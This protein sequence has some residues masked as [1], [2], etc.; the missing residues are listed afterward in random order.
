ML[1]KRWCHCLAAPHCSGHVVPVCKATSPFQATHSTLDHSL[2]CWSLTGDGERPRSPSPRASMVLSFWLCRKMTASNLVARGCRQYDVT[3]RLA[4]ETRW[5]SEELEAEV[6]CAE[7]F[8]AAGVLPHKYRCD[9]RF[10]TRSPLTW[11]C[12]AIIDPKPLKSLSV[13]GLPAFEHADPKGFC[14]A[15]Q[16][17]K[18]F[19]VFCCSDAADRVEWLKALRKVA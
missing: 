6:V 16:T 4:Y 19:Y 18:R 11:T 5:A 10:C 17:P 8:R 7:S 12:F 2:I 3:P 9:S 14:F 13:K 1:C 15:I